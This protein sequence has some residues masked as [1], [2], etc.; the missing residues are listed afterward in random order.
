MDFIERIE[1][2]V[3]R[4]SRKVCVSLK[5]KKRKACVVWRLSVVYQQAQKLIALPGRGRLG[6]FHPHVAAHAQAE[7]LR[8]G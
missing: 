6:L 5:E 7:V 1:R 2:E 4:F 8:G 3:T